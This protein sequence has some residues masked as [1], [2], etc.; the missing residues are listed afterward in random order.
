[1]K[2]F[3]DKDT[4]L[5]RYVVPEKIDLTSQIYCG[6]QQN[7]CYIVPCTLVLVPGSA[8]AKLNTKKHDTTANP[9]NIN[10]NDSDDDNE[11]YI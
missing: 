11:K 4:Y 2:G 7:T 8:A 9:I 10:H 1:M 5:T 6:Q 3:S